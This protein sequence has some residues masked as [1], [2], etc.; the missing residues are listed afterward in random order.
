MT[1]PSEARLLKALSDVRIPDGKRDIVSAG[2]VESVSA[3]DG[4]AQLVLAADGDE[5]QAWEQVS[6]AAR[7]A[8]AGVEGVEK[9]RV[10][11]TAHKAGPSVQETA[12]KPETKPEAP[13][14]AKDVKR[15]IAVASGKGGVGKS[16]VTANL[17]VALSQLGLKVGLLDADIY[18]PSQP[19]LL[20]LEGR[21]D[22][23]SDRK[24][25]T[26]MSAHG[27]KVLSIGS[28]VDAEQP[29]VWRG[30]MTSNA[31]LQMLNE[32]DW[33]ALDVL[34]VDM[35]PG[36]GDTALGL[37]QT[38]RLNGAVIVSTPQDLALIDARRS[39]AMFDKVNVPVF[40]V[41]ENMSQ[42][43]C[44]HCGQASDIFGHGG[45]RHEAEE[46][47]LPFLGEI[48]L[49]MRLRESGEEGAPLVATAPEDPAS[50][51][52]F[53]VARTLVERLR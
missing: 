26:P 31:M 39:I 43:I 51:V 9:A 13:D 15:I 23:D 49:T 29:M 11:L 50:V 5:P 16:T 47:G 36:T 48:P 14:G 1:D 35:P 37:A 53:D 24:R 40:G 34:L 52:Y 8:L 21:P 10:I 17:A 33:G 41:I 28:M 45:A 6:E 18:G 25:I 2:R 32:G 42:F 30:P 4:A 12:K 20:G 19:K 3:K 7:T 38:K 44:P 27:L 22:S 46:R